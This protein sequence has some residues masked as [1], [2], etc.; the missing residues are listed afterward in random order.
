MSTAFGID[1]DVDHICMFDGPVLKHDVLNG[2]IDKVA[3]S[4]MIT[5][6]EAFRKAVFDREAVSSTGIGGG[7]AIPH[8][9]L[10]EILEPIVA[11][12]VSK[13]G[14]DFDAIDGE[15][16]RVVILFAMPAGTD[17][18]YLQLLARVMSTLRESGFS[19]R[20]LECETPQSVAAVIQADLA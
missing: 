6:K 17:K 1:I 5:D 9:K 19:E 7:V 18:E 20:L 16:V 8:V 10:T 13:E 12:G 3:V 4:E 11:V 2:I 15:P 14:I